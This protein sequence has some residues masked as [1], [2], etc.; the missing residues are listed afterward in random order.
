VAAIDE[1]RKALP[2]HPG[3]PEAIRRLIEV[4]LVIKAKKRTP[5]PNN[6]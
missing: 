5:T 1:S 3:R 4:A 2:D 6:R